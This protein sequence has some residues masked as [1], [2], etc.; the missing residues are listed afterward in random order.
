LNII[1]GGIQVFDKEWLENLIELQKKTR[2]L[3]EKV[4][5]PKEYVDMI[6]KTIQNSAKSP[7][8]FDLPDYIREF[9]NLW[10]VGTHFVSDN[11]FEPKINVTETATAFLIKAAIPGLKNKDDIRVK[12]HGTVVNISGKT[13]NKSGEKNREDYLYFNKSIPLPVEVNPQKSTAEYSDGILTL[14][15]PKYSDA[16]TRQIEVT[17][18]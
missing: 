12:V 9:K 5:W 15:L 16:Q 17:F 14:Y 2:E 13:P 8:S 6:A 4:S 1:L 10:N 7:A 11:S 18:L 3:S